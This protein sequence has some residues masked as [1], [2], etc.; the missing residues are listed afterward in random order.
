MADW[1][2]KHDGPCACRFVRRE[3]FGEAEQTEWCGLHAAQRDELERLRGALKKANEQ[4]EHFEREW[5]L[6]GDALERAA[7]V[8]R[9]ACDGWNDLM[10]E[11]ARMAA[12]AVQALLV[13]NVLA[14]GRAACGA[15]L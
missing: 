13:P 4:A 7:D 1:P 11:G 15:S 3:E 9:N 14:Q 5:Y 12:D 8:A 10:H 6:R 2:L